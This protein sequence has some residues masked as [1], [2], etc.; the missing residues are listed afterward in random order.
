MCYCLAHIVHIESDPEYV[1][2]H[3]IEYKYVNCA[4]RI[5]DDDDID[6]PSANTYQ[7]IPII[8]TQL[9]LWRAKPCYD[10]FRHCMGKFVDAVAD[11]CF[12]CN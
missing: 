6:K 8:L 3:S 10:S 5:D 1:L 2:V 9:L 12:H 4:P 7:Y 11:G